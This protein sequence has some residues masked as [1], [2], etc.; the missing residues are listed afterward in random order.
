[1]DQLENFSFNLI[2][3]YNSKINDGITFNEYLEAIKHGIK[4]KKINHHFS[5]QINIPKLKAYLKNNKIKIFNIDNLNDKLRQINKDYNIT[6]KIYGKSNCSPYKIN[7]EYKD[8]T[9]IKC[10]KIRMEDLSIEN[11]RDSFDK[12]KEIYKND[13]DYIGEYI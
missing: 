6:D 2:K 3:N 5:S 8:I 10:F 12:I 9:N 13:Y 11:F 1:M 7:S 4:I